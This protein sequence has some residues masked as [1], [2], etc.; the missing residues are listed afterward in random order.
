[1]SKELTEAIRRVLEGFETGVF[2]RSV[3]KDNDPAWAMKLIPYLR[4]LA[5]LQEAV[6][7]EPPSR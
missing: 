7:E 5:V 6:G 2:V 4:A 1:M 3:E